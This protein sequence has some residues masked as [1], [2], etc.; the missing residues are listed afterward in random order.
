LFLM[1]RVLVAEI[2]TWVGCECCAGKLLSNWICVTITHLCKL[3]ATNSG[4]NLQRVC[5]RKLGRAL[6]F[7]LGW[8]FHK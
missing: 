1:R 2:V 5:L 8:L 4:Q 3:Q 7:S 6:N